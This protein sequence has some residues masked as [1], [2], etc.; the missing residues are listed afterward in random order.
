MEFAQTSRQPFVQPLVQSSVQPDIQRDHPD[1]PGET[2]MPNP[3]SSLY[4]LVNLSVNLL[5]DIAYEGISTPIQDLN[6]DSQVPYAN[7]EV[8]TKEENPLWDCNQSPE[9]CQ[10]PKPTVE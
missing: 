1:S 10:P 7:V 4:A 5:N 3:D 8:L 9:P 6:P 2:H